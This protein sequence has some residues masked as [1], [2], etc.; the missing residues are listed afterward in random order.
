MRINKV[1]IENFGNIEQ[2]NA[3]FSGRLNVICSEY[4]TDILSILAIITGSRTLGFNSTRHVFTQNTRI[5][6]S[7][8]GHF[9][10]V[11]VELFYDGGCEHCCASKVALNG[12]PSSF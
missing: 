2:F 6:A 3:Q 1:S 7:I 8:S 4:W 12:R 9:G 10:T 5:Y 11:E